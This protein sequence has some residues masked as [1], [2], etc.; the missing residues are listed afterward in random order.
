MT[1][2]REP[3]PDDLVAA[4]ADGAAIDWADVETPADRGQAELVH[5]LRV[6]D[7]LRAQHAGALRDRRWDARAVTGL[8]AAAVVLAAV[9]VLIGLIAVPRVLFAPVAPAG[10]G[11]FAL[12]L[13]VFGLGGLLLV[14]GGSRDRRLQLLGGFFVT[15]GAAFVQPFLPVRGGAAGVVVDVLRSCAPESFA[16]LLVWQFAWVFPHPPLSPAGQRAGRAFLGV[17]AAASVA[18]FLTHLSAQR[19]GDAPAALRLVQRLFDRDAPESLY[20]PFVFVLVLLAVAFMI[21]KARQVGGD[22]RRRTTWFLVAL[23]VGLLPVGLAVIATPFVPALADPDVRRRAGV[24]VYAGLLS[25]VPTTAFAV[26]VQRVMDLQFVIRTALQ[27]AL[28]RSAIRAAIA[29]PLGYLVLDIWVN[30]ARTFQQFLDERHPLPLLALGGLALVTLTYRAH[31]VRAADRW[32]LGAAASCC[33]A[34][35]EV[36]EPDVRRCA[37]GA[38]TRQADLPLVVHG[39]FRLHRR[40]GAGSTGVVYLATDLALCRLVALKT[41]QPLRRGFADRMRREARAM[42]A[43]RH[44]HLATIFG[45]EEW[46]DRP[47][48]VVEYLDGGTLADTLARGPLALDDALRLGIALADVLDRMHGGGVLHRDIKPSNIGF[49]ADGEPRLLDFGLAAMLD[50]VAPIAAVSGARHVVGTPLYL[51]PEALAGARPDESFDLWSLHMVIYEAIAGRHPLHGQPVA[52]VVRAVPGSTLPD[53]RALRPDCPA[54]LATYLAEALALELARRP[55]SASAVRA[56][57]GEMRRADGA[58]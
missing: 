47:V 4:I 57:L 5:Q 11:P 25:I 26:A 45:V 13:A 36:H 1:P 58:A 56:A 28:A 41:L 39:K 50:E 35:G 24:V 15:I 16:M 33:V 7:R 21:V 32:F 34:C 53:V 49:T 44:P 30:R 20:W 43:V 48:L 42:A 22:S 10:V 23:G 19:A 46:H 3:R 52:A 51:S 29:V 17:A 12:N 55:A 37:C 14:F 2:K 6:I 8:A 38:D 40:L 54:A 9:K 18:A 27:Y 31:L